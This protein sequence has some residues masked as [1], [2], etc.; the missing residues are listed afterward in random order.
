[1]YLSCRSR[2]ENAHS[3][4]STNAE[5]FEAGPYA[6][7]G[8]GAK[9][10][11]PGHRAEVGNCQIPSAQRMAEGAGK[12]IPD[13]SCVFLVLLVFS[14]PILTKMVSRMPKNVKELQYKFVAVKRPTD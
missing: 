13:N 11:D 12:D 3:S 1:M 6:A 7:G 10:A 8:H 4:S 14:A 5:P 9:V 2:C